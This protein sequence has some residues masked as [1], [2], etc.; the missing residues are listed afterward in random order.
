MKKMNKSIG[1]SALIISVVAIMG[2]CF[3][4]IREVLLSHYFGAT[5]I[6]DSYIMA[7]NIVGVL[8]GWV[9]TIYLCYT[10]IYIEIRQKENCEN[11]NK[12]TRTIITAFSIISVVCIILVNVYAER[13]V[14]FI[15]PGFSGVSL[16]LTK[17]FLRIAVLILLV[18]PAIYPLK[19]YLE[20]N[21]RFVSSSLSDFFLSFTQM[22][23][24]AISGLIDYRI[25]PFA[26]FV[27]YAVQMLIVAVSARK[28]GLKYYPQVAYSGHIKVLFSMVVPY[29]VSSL[30]V[31]IN[32]LVDRYF[33]SSLDVGSVAVVNYAAVLNSFLLNVFSVAI[34]TI[35]YPKLSEAIAKDDT[36]T[37]IMYTENGIKII[38]FLFLPLSVGAMILS[39][40]IVTCVYGHGA[41]S[42]DN[43]ESTSMVFKMYML[44][45]YFV[46]VRELLLRTLYSR[47][48][49][50]TPLIIGTI[51]TAANIGLNMLLVKKMGVQGLALST[52]VST[53]ITV[54]I[55]GL[56]IKKRYVDLNVWKLGSYIVKI[57]V[58]TAVMG[59]IV[60][61]LYNILLQYKS[62]YREYWMNVILCT[63]IGGVIYVLVSCF[64]IRNDNI[65][66]LIRRK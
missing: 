16:D 22:V 7:G 48:N 9:T 64:M 1:K 23:L 42:A 39:K 44:A 60:E 65:W 4:F 17:Y 21:D 15:A 40:G 26:M 13:V 56:I 45:I 8:F 63:V 5:E 2:K 34:M 25:L 19:A 24:V 27:P 32:S 18:E 37:Y 31:E 30:L 50:K 33:A 66:K 3:G 10:P 49:M 28:S 55:L 51:S 54:P 62:G 46:A 29:F 57:L 12:F 6:A 36:D 20:C 11:A 35:V 41:F 59:I 47:K 61:R 53:L 38:T 58:A 52:S 43:I 14:H